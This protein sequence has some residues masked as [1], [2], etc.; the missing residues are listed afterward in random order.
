VLNS[1]QSDLSAQGVAVGVTAGS[2]GNYGQVLKTK[3]FIFL[4]QVL[5]ESEITITRQNLI[6]TFFNR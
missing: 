2:D 1:A 4:D 3:G 5:K 6:F